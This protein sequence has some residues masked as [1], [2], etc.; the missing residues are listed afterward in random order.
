M[1][2]IKNICQSYGMD[3]AEIYEIMKNKECKYLLLLLMRE[4]QC[5]DKKFIK[6]Q[7]KLKSDRIIRNNIKRA[8]EKLLI[9]KEFR[10]EFFNLEGK[11]QKNI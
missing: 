8:E 3:N 7:L 10:E 2:I 4:F 1:I 9:N 6:E 11:I 5:F